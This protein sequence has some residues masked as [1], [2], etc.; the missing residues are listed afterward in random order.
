LRL[1]LA[2]AHL[3]SALAKTFHTKSVRFVA[4]FSPGS[5]PDTAEVKERLGTVGFEP[6]ISSPGELTNAMG[7]KSRM[8]S[9]FVKRAKIT[10]N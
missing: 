3:R 4:P 10:L 1:S 9:E 6:L 8:F 2:T 5:G 7:H